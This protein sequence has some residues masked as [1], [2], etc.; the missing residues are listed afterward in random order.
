MS[1]T[2]TDDRHGAEPHVAHVISEQAKSSAGAGG[3]AWSGAASERERR[4]AGA[5]GGLS[6]RMAAHSSGH[7]GVNNCFMT[8]VTLLY[9]A[10]GASHGGRALCQAC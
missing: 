7:D 8:A 10:R 3:A 2:A 4:G 9:E 5:C 1:R 6:G